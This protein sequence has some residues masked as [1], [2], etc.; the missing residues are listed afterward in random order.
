M[1]RISRADALAPMDYLDAADVYLDV[2]SKIGD[3]GMHRLRWAIAMRVAYK[4]DRDRHDVVYLHHMRDLCDDGYGYMSAYVY[5]RAI[6]ECL[7]AE[8]VLAHES[9]RGVEGYVVA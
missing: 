4:D 7:V 5:I 3:E 9:Y 1:G 2:Y 8:H 6:L